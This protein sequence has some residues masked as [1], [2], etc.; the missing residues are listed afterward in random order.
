LTFL[1]TDLIFQ[2]YPINLGVNV[3]KNLENVSL[4]ILDSRMFLLT[5]TNYQ[6]D[7][8]DIMLVKLNSN[9]E[10]EWGPL[11][12]GGEGDDFAGSVSELPDGKIL[13]MGTMTLG[14][15][16]VE[17]QKKMVLI[18]LNPEGKLTE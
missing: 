1:K 8:P 3:A 15:N 5:A 14:G 12:F 17:G 4:S 9:M 10:V 2:K 6:T 7:N 13:L 11:I 18:K 16:N